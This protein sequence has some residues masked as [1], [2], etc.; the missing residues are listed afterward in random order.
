[1]KYL[2]LFLGIFL[3]AEAKEVPV[4]VKTDT[5][6]AKIVNI[7]PNSNIDTSLPFTANE[8]IT[9]KNGLN[10]NSNEDT[11][12]TAVLSGQNLDYSQMNAF[13]SALNKLQNEK[14]LSS[15]EKKY[16]LKGNV[17]EK[18]KYLSRKKIMDF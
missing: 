15:D 8:K 13:V 1:M 11:V 10:L 18:V 2:L 5:L 7:L 14:G 12:L 3:I 6:N 4:L 9:V 16:L 17:Y